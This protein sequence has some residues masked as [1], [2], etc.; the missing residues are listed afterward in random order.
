MTAIERLLSGDWGT[1]RL[2]QSAVPVD[3]MVLVPGAILW[4]GVLLWRG[5]AAGG[6][7]FR[8]TA[9]FLFVLLFLTSATRSLIVRRLMPP[10]FLGGLLM[11]VMLPAI[12]ALQDVAIGDFILPPVEEMLKLVP[13]LLILR[14]GAQSESWTLGA[15][16]V[17]LVAAV[18]A[19]GFNLAEQT[20]LGPSDGPEPGLYGLL[21]S[22]LN[23]SRLSAGHIA[24]SSLAGATIGLGL[25]W[26]S[27]RWLAPLV[28]VSGLCLSII[29]HVAS[30]Y[31]TGHNDRLA[32]MLRAGTIDG[33]LVCYLAVAG[34]VLAI[35]IDF[36]INHATLP[37]L[38]ELEEPLG[39]ESLRGSWRFA[40]GKRALAHAV[41]QYR[42]LSGLDRANA[43][44]A[45]ASLD[46]WFLNLRAFFE[47]TV[48]EAPTAAG[49]PTGA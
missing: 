35:A 29:D 49:T 14:R 17:L 10:F 31:R 34:F 3:L 8:N 21:G 46:A 44:C 37:E 6:A 24:W 47:Y 39:L 12:Y 33:W 23:H 25:L 26:R 32:T 7:A 18:T 27:K 43:I 22:H 13:V 45:A 19:A 40:L 9:L 5:G 1:V 4:L 30:N 48:D 28:G 2:R 42:R 38:P 11:C 15:T 16:D 20:Y 41:F 36:Y